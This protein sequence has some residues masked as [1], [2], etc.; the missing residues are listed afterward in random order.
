M[1]DIK[2]AILGFNT[3]IGK[4]LFDILENE[5][6]VLQDIFPLSYSCQE[7]D[8]ATFLGKNY[9][10]Q[11]P[12]DFDFEQ[13]NLFI[14]IGHEGNA[15]ALISRAKNAGVQVID[16]SGL[17]NEEA[18][19]YADGMNALSADDLSAENVIVPMN[20]SATFLSLIL[21]PLHDVFGIKDVTSTLIESVSSLGQDG[22]SELARETISLLNMRDISPKLFKDQVAF[23]VHTAVGEIMADGITTHEESVL[24]ELE[25]VLP[26]ISSNINLTIYTAPVF[27][28]HTNSL[29]IELNRSDLSVTDIKDVL[30]KTNAIEVEDEDI[31]PAKYGVNE[32]KIFVSRI[33]QNKNNPCKFSM[34]AIM[35]NAKRGVAMNCAGIIKLILQR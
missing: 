25:N 9:L 32:E 23:N 33:R 17:E 5:N 22:A 21:K 13:A 29:T 28:G 27:Y 34:N 14:I 16:V 8:A 26:E 18:Y 15:P 4:G 30:E 7:Y 20:S 24:A 1:S 12:N 11:N 35:D 3:D 2:L 6:I 10:I 31:S 19:I